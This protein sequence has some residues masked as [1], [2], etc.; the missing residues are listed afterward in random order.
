[1]TDELFPRLTFNH[2]MQTIAVIGAVQQYVTDMR[3]TYP[4]TM[5]MDAA[6]EIGGLITAAK[7][8]DRYRYVAQCQRLRIP[9]ACWNRIWIDNQPFAHG[10]YIPFQDGHNRGRWI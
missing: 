4:T 8:N 10:H 2:L 3:A 5:Q 7:L 6:F 9:H 1:M